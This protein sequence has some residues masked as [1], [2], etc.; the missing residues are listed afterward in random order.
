MMIQ[1]N[2]FE[3]RTLIPILK[4]AGEKEL[5]NYQFFDAGSAEREQVNLRIEAIHSIIK[6]L[7]GGR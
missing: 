4:A 6:K 1:L 3:V 7:G 2:D 5:K